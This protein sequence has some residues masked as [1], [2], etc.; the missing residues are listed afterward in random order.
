MKQTALQTEELD[1]GS[2]EKLQLKIGAAV[3]FFIQP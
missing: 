2:V 3:G 1:T